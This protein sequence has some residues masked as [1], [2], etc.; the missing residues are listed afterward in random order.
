MSSRTVGYILYLK[1]LKYT[2]KDDE[3]DVAQCIYRLDIDYILILQMHL[4]M[5]KPRHVYDI[6]DNCSKLHPPFFLICF[7]FVVSCVWILFLQKQNPSVSCM[8]SSFLLYII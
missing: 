7:F 2:M 1:A 8:V 4:P 5:H 6:K 3:F